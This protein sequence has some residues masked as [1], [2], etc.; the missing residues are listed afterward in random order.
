MIKALKIGCFMVAFWLVATCAFAIS[1]ADVSVASGVIANTHAH[2]TTSPNCIVYGFNVVAIQNGGY[3]RIV[4]S[5]TTPNVAA[6]AETIGQHI[7]TSTANTVLAHV[8]IITALGT[9]YISFPKGV[10]C[11]GKLFVDCHGAS[12]E[13]YYK[14]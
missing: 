1:L 4:S 8:Q 3:A 12:A 10:G 13:V 6:D 7:V 9:E 11:N 5:N 2:V 14:E